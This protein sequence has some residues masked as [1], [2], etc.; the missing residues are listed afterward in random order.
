MPQNYLGSEIV[1]SG[2]YWLVG[3]KYKPVI[4]VDGFT[5]KTGRIAGILMA[6]EPGEYDG[7]GEIAKSP[8]AVKVDPN[9]LGERLVYDELLGIKTDLIRKF[10]Y[11]IN[12]F[13]KE[14]V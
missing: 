10:T 3:F 5:K 9:R 6:T 13:F 4:R 14:E 8:I 12:S 11:R 2:F 7:I 1:V